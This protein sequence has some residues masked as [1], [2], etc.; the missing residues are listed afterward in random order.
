MQKIYGEEGMRRTVEAILV[1][2]SHNHPHVLVLQMRAGFHSLPGGKLKPGEEETAGLKR[3]LHSKLA[4]ATA[5][6]SDW[7]VGECLATWWRP[8]FETV[9]MYPYMPP[10]VTRPKECRKLFLVHLPERCYFAV[11]KNLKLLAV[12][13]FELFDN[14]PRYGHLLAAIPQC[15]SRFHFNMID[16][17]EAAAE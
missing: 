7:E 17:D 9:A 16:A 5:A 13:L 15:L 14:V 3:K 12:P 6:S 4:P 1:V 11:P 10:H 2:N 8:T